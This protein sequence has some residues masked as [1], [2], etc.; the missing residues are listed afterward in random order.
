MLIL[1]AF[2]HY[3]LFIWAC[4][5]DRT[6]KF[7]H[8]KI[9]IRTLELKLQHFPHMGS[10]AFA[11]FESQCAL[12]RKLL[13]GI[14]FRGSWRDEESVTTVAPPFLLRGRWVYIV[15]GCGN[16]E[17]IT[18]WF[19][20]VM[21]VCVIFSCM[22]AL[23]TAVE[24]RKQLHVAGATGWVWFWWIILVIFVSGKCDKCTWWECIYR[25]LC[26]TS[27]LLV[28]TPVLK[29]WPNTVCPEIFEGSNFCGRPIFKDF[30][31]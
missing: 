18:K 7:W 29:K 24:Y 10:H 14:V 9:L 2:D 6:W 23:S 22:V 11:M 30:A 1:R 4:R 27:A 15:D 28:P 12:F 13:A 20:A 3:K 26:M 5:M 25:G 21:F 16:Y 17:N 31:I 8:E 19:R